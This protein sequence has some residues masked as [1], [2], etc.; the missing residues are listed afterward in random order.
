MSSELRRI[1]E[2][3]EGL[4]HLFERAQVLQPQPTHVA[5]SEVPPAWA[6]AAS[7]PSRNSVAD[8]VGPGKEV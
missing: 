1:A 6:R 5:D 8:S 4:L 3:V 7:E 2:A